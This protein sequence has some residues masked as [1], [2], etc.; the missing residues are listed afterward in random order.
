MITIKTKIVDCIYCVNCPAKLY[1]KNNTE[2][3]LGFGNLYANKIIIV[4]T[5]SVDYKKT[6]NYISSI[7]ILKDYLPN[8]EENYYI[9]R[10]AKCYIPQYNI[11]NDIG[12]YCSLVLNRELAK[13]Q[14]KY[15]FVFG[16][17]DLSYVHRLI[18]N[19]YRIKRYYNPYCLVVGNDYVKNQFK[20][21]LKEMES[22]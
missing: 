16:D 12:K 13:L 4:P 18:L 9:T 22:L 8:I 6:G 5:Y 3:K 1:A 14:A 17:V 2:V 7:S 11:N 20:E 15:I 19:R 21:Q 10:D